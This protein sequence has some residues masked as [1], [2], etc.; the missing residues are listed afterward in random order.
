MINVIIPAYKPDERFKKLLSMLNEQTCAPDRIIVIN[1]EEKYWDESIKA[2]NLNLIHISKAEFDHG[3]TRNKGMAMADSDICIMMT[4]DA[5][6]ADNKLIENLIKPLEDERVA[7]SYARQLAYDNSSLIEKMTRDFN[8]PD[9]SLI[10]TAADIERLQIK[11]FF[12]SNV[13]CAYNKR[14]FDEL[15]GFVK[16]TIFNEDMLFAAKAIEAGYAIAYCA[17]ARVYHSH[18]YSGIMQ[19]HRNFDNGVSHAQYPE[20][21]S[22]VSQDGEGFKMVRTVLG[23]LMKK[24][25]I[26]EAVRYFWS[27]GCKFLGFK[28]GC[29]YKKLPKWMVLAFTSDKSYFE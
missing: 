11:A 25:H 8:Y 5:V 10:K 18:E 14:I 26:I 6:P 13:C 27:S 12:C 3:N 4:M 16:K 7:A 22:K 17:Q 20:V 29:R 23:R 1:T 24:G 28:L 9:E 2:D 21:F 15:G 19:F